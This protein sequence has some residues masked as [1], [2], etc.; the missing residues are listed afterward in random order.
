MLRKWASG[1]P[2]PPHLF[3]GGVSI[4]QFDDIIIFV[5]HDLENA[6]NMK[7]IICTFEH[8]SGLNINLHKS[9]RFC[10]VKAKHA[11]D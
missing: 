10:F 7:L 4:L 5:E 9:E 2:K 1:G 3:E 11:E 6:L 8:L